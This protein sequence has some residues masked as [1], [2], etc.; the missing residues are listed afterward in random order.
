MMTLLHAEICIIAIVA[1]VTC[2]L[3]GVFLVLR[4]VAMMSDAISHAIL[5][6]IAL[7]FLWVQRLESPLLI[8][9][10][11]CAGVLTVICTEMIIRSKRLKK[12]AAIGLVFPLFFS[13]GV[14]LISQY[15]R[16]VHLDVDMVLLGELA[17]ASFSRFFIAGFD[18]GPYALWVMSAALLVNVSFLVIFYKE[19]LVTTFDAT[20]ATMTGFSP[21]F[22]YYALMVL[23]SITAVA[24]FDAVGSIMVVALM[25]TPAAS[26]YLL[27]R[28]VSDMIM[29]SV[30]LASLAAIGGY[31]AA[32]YAD[33]SIAGSIASMTGIFFIL[34]LIWSQ[35][36][37]AWGQNDPFSLS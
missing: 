14:I 13:V 36:R 33:V 27:T 6:G 26:A 9:G 20:F 24:T 16:N 25:I 31:V 30:L 34:A 18:C 19:L 21:L 35:N 37:A 23:T 15:A 32:S 3:P 17:F 8:V 22:F 2:C 29:V 1:S 5:L 12:D 11:S 28:R 10:A 4:G 7:M